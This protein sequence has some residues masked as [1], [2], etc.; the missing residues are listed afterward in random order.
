MSG[1]G[2]YYFVARPPMLQMVGADDQQS[3]QFAVSAG[4]RMQRDGVHPAD[5]G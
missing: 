5:F 3:G 4:R 1:V 2:N